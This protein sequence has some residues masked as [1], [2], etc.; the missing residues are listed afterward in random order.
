M[1]E[2]SEWVW[3]P[4]V[5]HLIVGNHCRFRLNTCV[6]DF[7]VSTVGEYLPQESMWDI[8]AKSKGI[9]L[10]GRGDAREADFIDRVGYEDLGLDRKFE[11]MVFQSRTITNNSCCP[12]EP[13]SWENVDGAGYNEAGAARL[14][15][16]AMCEKW[17][18]ESAR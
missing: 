16:M 6:G 9:T 13:G 4:H 5:G 15:H 8:F 11:T 2:R 10:K 14:G 17:S 7:I 18:K 1:S 3:M 12:F